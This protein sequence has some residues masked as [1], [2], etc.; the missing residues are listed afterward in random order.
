MPF[1]MW[2]EFESAATGSDALEDHP[3]WFISI[4]GRDRHVLDLSNPR[5]QNWSIDTIS[6]WVERLNLGVV[7][8]DATFSPLPY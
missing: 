2:F 6:E 8:L 7:R 1:D 4:D 3:E 5:A